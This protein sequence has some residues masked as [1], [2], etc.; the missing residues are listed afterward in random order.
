[1]KTLMRNST[2]FLTTAVIFTSLIGCGKVNASSSQTSTAEPVA[3]PVAATPT[4]V[5][6]EL[7]SFEEGYEVG[8]H[9]GTMIVQRVQDKTINTKGC[10]EIGKL[11][12][13]LINVVKNVRAPSN[14]GS[15]FVKGFYTGYLDSIRK[16]VQDSKQICGSISYDDGGF[17]GSLYGSLLCSV[18]SIN[19]DIATS[20]EVVHLYDGWSGGSSTVLNQC[21]TN[22]ALELKSCSSE[23]QD[24]TT[25]L[26]LQLKTSC[27]DASPEVVVTGE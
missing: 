24:L 10:E 20:L 13:A 19:V 18:S 6:P 11:E 25:I 5:V 1:M 22:L 9:N 26:G 16:G 17:A 8:L 7:P 15:D 21:E 3:T 23:T 27:S 2:L 14:S 12:K 4:K